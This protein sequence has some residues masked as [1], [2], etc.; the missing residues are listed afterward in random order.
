[1]TLSSD[2]GLT[3]QTLSISGIIVDSPRVIVDSTPYMELEK[4]YILQVDADMKE[5]D[6]IWSA[7]MLDW[8]SM[9]Y[10]LGEAGT[11]FE[12]NQNQDFLE[13]FCR[14]MAF[15]ALLNKSATRGAKYIAG[16]QMLA[17]KLALGAGQASQSRLNFSN[18]GTP[19]SQSVL[20]ES[21]FQ[22]LS[23]GRKFCVTSE[24]SMAWVPKDTRL[25]D[26]ICFLAGCAVPFVIRPM[27][28]SFELLGDCYLHRISSDESITFARKP[29]IL[30]FQ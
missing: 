4:P 13:A 30:Q 11:S 17:S 18:C 29:R 25:G 3:A 10:M 2:C 22:E 14:T 16:F 19:V 9:C 8:Q 12:G 5:K 28:K 7:K 21:R 26:L 6:A 15:N 23:A 27:G 1:M 20:Y 24:R